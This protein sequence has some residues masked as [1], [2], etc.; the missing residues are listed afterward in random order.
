MAKIPLFPRS[1][2]KANKLTDEEQTNRRHD[3]RSLEPDEIRRLL[4]ATQTAPERFGM[5]GRSLI[6]SFGYRNGAET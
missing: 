6:V 4:E 3:R 5:D 1:H 2:H